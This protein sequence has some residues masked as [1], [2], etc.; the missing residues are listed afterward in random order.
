[1]IGTFLRKAGGGNR[2]QSEFVCQWVL[3][4]YEIGRTKL[5]FWT[6]VGH[7][8]GRKRLQRPLRN[9][10]VIG[11]VEYPSTGKWKALMAARWTLV[12]LSN[13]PQLFSSRMQA[14]MSGSKEVAGSMCLTSYQHANLVHFCKCSVQTL[15]CCVVTFFLLAVNR[16]FPCLRTIDKPCFKVKDSEVG[17]RIFPLSWERWRGVAWRVISENMASCIR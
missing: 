1:M 2:F 3:Q 5:R 15:F 12:E 13:S 7:L 8:T 14:S 6:V 17:W 4:D 9:L 11:Q 10:I 16:P